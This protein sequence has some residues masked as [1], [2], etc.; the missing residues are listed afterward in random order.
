MAYF[1]FVEINTGKAEFG[2]CEPFVGVGT[3]VFIT[4]Y[5]SMN[6]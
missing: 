4:V 2:L 1:D 3:A 6:L 5:T